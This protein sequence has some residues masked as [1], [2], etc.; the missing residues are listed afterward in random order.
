MM[1]RLT[2]CRKSCRLGTPRESRDEVEMTVVIP[3]IK[4]NVG[5]TM[6]VGVQPFHRECSSGQ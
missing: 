1:A 6:S 3:M 2:I 4:R 5:K